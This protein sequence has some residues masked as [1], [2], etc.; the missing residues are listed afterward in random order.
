MRCRPA[1]S[2]ASLAKKH[3]RLKLPRDV[4]GQRRIKALEI[5]WYRPTRQTRSHVQVTTSLDGEHHI[6]VSLH[7]PVKAG[8][9][10]AIVRDVAAHHGVSRD[11]LIGKRFG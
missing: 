3:R 1:S 6:T 11:E 4:S 7:D 5:L 8:T 2:C 10:S 9:V